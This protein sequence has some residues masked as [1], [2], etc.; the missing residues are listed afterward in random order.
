MF[1]GRSSTDIFSFDRKPNNSFPAS[2]FEPYFPYAD[3]W[4]EF[5]KLKK[6]ANGRGPFGLVRSIVEGSL[7]SVGLLG[8]H[9][10]SKHY[11]WSILVSSGL[12]V[13][14]QLAFE[15]IARKRFIHWPCPRCHSE[16][17][18]TTTEKDR[19]CK[20]RGLRLHQLSP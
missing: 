12:L 14:L 6:R 16:W 7:V 4:N 11:G 10:I 5:D 3:A 17:P 2:S 18:G 15:P 13:A 19:A 1:D 20:T 8:W 9:N